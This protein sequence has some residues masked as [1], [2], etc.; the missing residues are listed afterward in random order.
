MREPAVVKRAQRASFV[1][2]FSLFA[3]ALPMD[4]WPATMRELSN[5]KRTQTIRTVYAL[6]SSHFHFMG[7]DSKESWGG[8]HEEVTQGKRI[9]P[10]ILRTAFRAFQFRGNSGALT[11]LLWVNSLYF[12][13]LRHQTGVFKQSKSKRMRISEEKQI[14]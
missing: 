12:Q 9:T 13:K 10:A 7:N 6:F 3:T 8:M 11:R 1:F 5:V 2:F 4:E 14:G